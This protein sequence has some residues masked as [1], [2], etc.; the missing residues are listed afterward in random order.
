MDPKR[1][2]LE[3]YET[4]GRRRTVGLRALDE[5]SSSRGPDRL[6]VVAIGSVLSDGRYDGPH[7]ASSCIVEF[8]NELC[9]FTSM[10]MVELMGYVAHSQTQAIYV[11]SG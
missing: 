8:K 11:T 9:D 2:E 4:E 7:E 10:P 3:I 5:I 1:P 6:T